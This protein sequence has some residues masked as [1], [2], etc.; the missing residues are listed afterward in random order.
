VMNLLPLPIVDGGVIVLLLVEKLRG[1]PLSEKVQE[2]ISYAGIAF[3]L[4]VFLWLTYNDIL[5]ILFG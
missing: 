5:R 1:K 2:I 4:A 3:L